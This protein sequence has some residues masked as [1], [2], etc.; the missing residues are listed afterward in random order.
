MIREPTS[1]LLT[2]HGGFVSC[3][4]FSPDGRWL[5][6]GSL[7]GDAR[8]WDLNQPDLQTSCSVL[9]GHGD[10]VLAL[11]ISADSRWLATAARDRSV[12]VWDLAANDPSAT[13][14][15]LRG[16]DDAPLAVA[17]DL[18]ANNLVSASADGT[19]RLF[20][21]RAGLPSAASS[22][23]YRHG[24]TRIQTLALSP[25]GRW[26]ASC[27]NDAVVRVWDRRAGRLHA[28]LPH[29][30]AVQLAEFSADDRWLVTVEMAQVARPPKLWDLNEK[31][32]DMT[33]RALRGHARPI[34]SLA[35]D[36]HSR[37]VIAGDQ[38]QRDGNLGGRVLRWPLP[39]GETRE[40]EVL[41]RHQG[42]VAWLALRH[43]AL[44]LTSVDRLGGVRVIPW[45]NAGAPAAEYTLPGQAEGVR[46]FAAFPDGRRLATVDF[47][48]ALRL[49]EPG[50]SND[51]GTVATVLWNQKPSA[52]HVVVS[53]DGHCL[54]ALDAAGRVLIWRFDDAGGAAMAPNAPPLI[55]SDAKSR[56]GALGCVI[57]PDNRRLATFAQDGFVRI[58]TLD[59][60]TRAPLVLEAHAKQV[61]AAHFT[62]DGRTLITAGYDGMVREWPLE[63]DDLVAHARRVAGRTL[64]DLERRQNVEE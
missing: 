21:L 32:A 63:V 56:G 62:P 24:D 18:G 49:W 16:H 43:D 52:R 5:V 31:P 10:R 30:D 6:S 54:A 42:D 2:G 48:G 9:A 15:V 45:E 3:V 34:E 4:A 27:G 59:A 36:P 50:A 12:R 53:G 13:S 46:S 41:A 26:L 40:G 38:Y 64:T 1:T 51:S 20:D 47:G 35:I 19:A 28:E 29:D 55:L 25:S 14:R 8:R 39:L 17:F 44:S 37:W 22:R 33:P 23:T 61:Q 58:W 11:A 57:S 7:D 60:P